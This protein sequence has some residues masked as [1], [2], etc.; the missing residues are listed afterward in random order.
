MVDIE[1][2]SELLRNEDAFRWLLLWI[3]DEFDWEW[4]IY[5]GGYGACNIRWLLLWI[6]DEFDTRL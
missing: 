4:Y 3:D 5:G 6:D 2:A 1:A